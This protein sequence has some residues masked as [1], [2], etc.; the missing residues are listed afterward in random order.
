MRVDVAEILRIKGIGKRRLID[1]ARFLRD[2]GIE[3]TDTSGSL[4]TCARFSRKQLREDL[5]KLRVELWGL[6][7][8][9]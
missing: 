7:V 6:D 9:R 8:D 1:V 3:M 5:L 2:H 4:E